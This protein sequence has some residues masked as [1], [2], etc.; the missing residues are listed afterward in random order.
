VR[1]KDES[2]RYYAENVSFPFS[3]AFIF[4]CFIRRYSPRRIIEIGSGFSSAAALDSLD[5][6]GKNDTQCWFIEPY[7][8][9][10]QS[11]LREADTRHGVLPSAVQEVDLTVFDSLAAGDILFIDSTHVSKINSDV[12]YEIFDILPRLK[13]GVLIHIHDIYWPFDYPE[14]WIHEGRAWT[15]SYLVRAFLQFNNDF[16]ILYF[17]SYLH[18]KVRRSLFVPLGVDLG[19]NDGGSLWLERV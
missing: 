15:E 6:L 10:L 16:R 4:Y 7:P 8:R 11:L 12:N 2:K 5:S 3:D 1:F 19:E 13:P 9:L 17:N 14:E 18:P